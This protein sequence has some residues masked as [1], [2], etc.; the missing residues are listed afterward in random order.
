M[1]HVL[2]CD[3][4]RP[5]G[6][7]DGDHVTL[8][9][10]RPTS[11]LYGG[12]RPPRGRVWGSFLIASAVLSGWALFHGL[13][14]FTVSVIALLGLSGWGAVLP[15]WRYV[16]GEALLGF[17][18]LLMV[19]TYVTGDDL[20]HSLE[21]LVGSALL[22]VVGLIQLF[23]SDRGEGHPSQVSISTGSPE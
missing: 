10:P 7:D 2:G 20:T 9:P 8:Q 15:R 14:W 22:V 21:R 5:P 17:A 6:P 18:V 13:D 11:P 12:R 3:L 16:A 1:R 23:L 19:I 4:K